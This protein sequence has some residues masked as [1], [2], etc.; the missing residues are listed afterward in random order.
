MATGGSHHSLLECRKRSVHLNLAYFP[1]LRLQLL[2]VQVRA[3]ELNDGKMTG[4]LPRVKFEV[5][6]TQL[7]K[8]GCRWL[9]ACGEVCIFCLPRHNLCASRPTHQSQVECCYFSADHPGSEDACAWAAPV[10]LSGERRKSALFLFSDDLHKLSIFTVRKWVRFPVL[11]P[12]FSNV[13]F[14]A[15][16]TELLKRVFNSS[17]RVR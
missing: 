10:L 3:M 11:N 5:C 8:L 15:L 16:T 6:I 7:C 1:P 12:P 17:E 14:R 13:L 4:T 2:M 9:S